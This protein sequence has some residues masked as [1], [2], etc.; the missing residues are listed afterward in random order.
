MAVNR[1][2]TYACHLNLIQVDH[3]KRLNYICPLWRIVTASKFRPVRLS[4]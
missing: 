4:G 1:F 2:P 3:L